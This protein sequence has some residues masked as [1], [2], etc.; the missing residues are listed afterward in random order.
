M[1]NIWGGGGGGWGGKGL[2]GWTITGGTFFLRLPLVIL[3]IYPVSMDSRNA[4]QVTVQV[5]D[6]ELKTQHQ[7]GQTSCLKT[8]KIKSRHYTQELK[9][10]SFIRKLLDIL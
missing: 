8:F 1:P 3:A 5:K 10:L 4:R 7:I 9:Y 6:L 2:S